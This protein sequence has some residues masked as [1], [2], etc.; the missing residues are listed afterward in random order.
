[1]WGK[2][3]WV[4]KFWKLHTLTHPPPLKG[5][6]ECWLAHLC[7][8]RQ[9]QRKVKKNHGHFLPTANFLLPKYGRRR[10]CEDASKKPFLPL[11]S[12][13]C[14][15]REEEVFHTFSRL[16][17]KRGTFFCPLPTSWSVIGSQGGKG[18]RKDL[19]SSNTN[20]CHF[21]N[22]IKKKTIFFAISNFFPPQ[23]RRLLMSAGIRPWRIERWG[24]GGSQK[25]ALL[26]HG[27]TLRIR[28]ELRALW[29]RGQKSC[30]KNKRGLIRLH[31][32]KRPFAQFLSFSLSLLTF[33]I[34]LCFATY[35][36]PLFSFFLLRGKL[37]DAI[38]QSRV[39]CTYPSLRCLR[40]AEIQQRFRLA[41]KRNSTCFFFFGTLHVNSN[42]VRSTEKAA[43]SGK[44]WYFFIQCPSSTLQKKGG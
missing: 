17:K 39:P 4:R 31:Y 5:G 22:C 14:C 29:I 7:F 23:T 32:K 40:S 3:E 30:L 10:V 11:F 35:N 6:E 25:G 36:F 13:P 9:I 20:Y 21:P 8:P 15:R 28:N 44:F 2:S 37:W 38:I 1:M 24:G 26:S 12:R 16:P 43:L 34:L 42:V 41:R 33:A 19:F 18:R 27:P